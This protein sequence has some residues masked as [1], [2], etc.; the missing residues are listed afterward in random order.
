MNIV[1]T[2]N[3]RTWLHKS[4]EKKINDHTLRGI[5]HKYMKNN[6]WLIQATG[7]LEI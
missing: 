1:M 3:Y 5:Q 2:Q 6:M 7:L 4:Q